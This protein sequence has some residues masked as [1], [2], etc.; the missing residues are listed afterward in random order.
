MKETF[1]DFI[2]KIE[3]SGE[4]LKIGFPPNSITIQQRW[5]NEA[6]ATS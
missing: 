3:G 5:R 2:E 1:G 4:Y 6:L